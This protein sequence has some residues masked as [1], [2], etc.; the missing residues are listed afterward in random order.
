MASS[1]QDEQRT[2]LVVEDDAPL[3][4]TL[5]YNLRAEGYQVLTGLAAGDKVVTDGALFLQFA[6]SQ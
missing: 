1:A 3:L 6:E 5:T 2:I 4:D